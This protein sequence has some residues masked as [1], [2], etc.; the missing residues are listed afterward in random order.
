V[1]ILAKIFFILLPRLFKEM[2]SKSMKALYIVLQHI[3]TKNQQKLQKMI[4]ATENL[5]YA[6][7]LKNYQE[8][9]NAWSFADV[10]TLEIVHSIL[11]HLQSNG[12]DPFKSDSKYDCANISDC[13]NKFTSPTQKKYGWQM[14]A[15]RGYNCCVHPHG[16]A[17]VCLF[18]I[19]EIQY[20]DCEIVPSTS[21]PSLE[22]PKVY[23][24]L[25]TI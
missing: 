17:V 24:Y 14:L 18:G 19:D 5:D 2:E 4:K 12:M 21:N 8:N 10:T 9:M 20:T 11:N 25:E 15:T 7:K 23:P 6:M 16:E 3:G 13:I 1:K 22:L